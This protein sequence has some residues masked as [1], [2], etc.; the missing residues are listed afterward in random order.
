MKDMELDY[1]KDVKSTRLRFNLTMII[2]ILIGFLF[3]FLYIAIIRKLSPLKKLN[4]QI[5][6]FAKGD[7]NIKISYKSEDEIGQIAQS[8]S[9]AIYYIKTLLESKNLFMRNMMHELKTPITKGRIAIELIEDS[10]SKKTLIRAFE[11]MN[12][13]IN[14]LAYIERL[15]TNK[16]KPDFKEVNINKL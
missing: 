4:E 14:E 15:T 13:L 16:F 8:F 6:Q 5:S 2:A 7:M 11:R 1:V 12:E 10:N 9:K 3:L